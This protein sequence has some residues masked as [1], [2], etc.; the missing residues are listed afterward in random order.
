[1]QQE[2]TLRD[3]LKSQG[4]ICLSE[5]DLEDHRKEDGASKSLIKQADSPTTKNKKKTDHPP[6]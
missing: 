1:M 4:T 2:W 6:P 3:W 5:E